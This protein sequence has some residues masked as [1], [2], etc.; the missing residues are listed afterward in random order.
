VVGPGVGGGVEGG[1][2]A[3][4]VGGPVGTG[5]LLDEGDAHRASRRGGGS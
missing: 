2:A 3:L 1:E 5:G 4:Q